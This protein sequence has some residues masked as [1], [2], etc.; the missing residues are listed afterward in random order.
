MPSV[1]FPAIW[2]GANELAHRVAGVTGAT[3]V[4]TTATDVNALPS[5]D[6]IAKKCGYIIDN[7][8]LIKSVNMAFLRN[9]TVGLIDPLPSLLKA[10]PERFRTEHGGEG[11][12]VQCSDLL[13]P[14]PRETL[15]LRP[16]SLVV[17]MGC[18]R[19]TTEAELMT[20]LTTSFQHLGLSI[21][22]SFSPCHHRG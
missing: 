6:M 18:N 13:F 12:F 10:L 20:L 16:R 3:P 8:K 22:K 7:P 1:L 15:V 2:G 19:G 14:V 9:E 17:G 4:I 5:I 11:V 21:E